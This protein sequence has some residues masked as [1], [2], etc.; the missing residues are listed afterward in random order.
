MKL[1]RTLAP[2]WRAAMSILR[3]AA[4]S[5]ICS[6]PMG[7]DPKDKNAEQTICKR[8]TRVIRKVWPDGWTTV[9]S[10]VG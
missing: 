7:H 6:P 2:P 8:C 10:E 1:S 3:K 9:H 5:I 4:S